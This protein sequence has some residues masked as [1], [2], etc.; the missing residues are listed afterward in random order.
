M[1]KIFKNKLLWLSLG[2]VTSAFGFTSCAQKQEQKQED[3]Y[4]LT[5]KA[6]ENY[7]KEAVADSYKSALALS[8][9]FYNNS[10]ETSDD[11]DLFIKQIN[12]KGKN[13]EV[14]YKGA[15][16]LFGSQ[17]YI[18]KINKI[19][20]DFISLIEYASKEGRDK[21][22]LKGK[23]K[24]FIKTV[25]KSVFGKD[26]W[27]Q[28][29]KSFLNDLQTNQSDL[30]SA[31][32]S[33]TSMLS[34]G[35]DLPFAI[36]KETIDLMLKDNET[37][38]SSLEYQINQLSDSNILAL[39]FALSE[40]DQKSKQTIL[41]LI[42][43]LKNWKIESDNDL[44]KLN[45]YD[46]LLQ[47]KP[48]P[49]LDERVKKLYFNLNDIIYNGGEKVKKLSKDEKNKFLQLLRE[50]KEEMKYSSGSIFGD[51]SRLWTQSANLFS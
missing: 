12:E 24:E 34:S 9:A 20:N 30:L 22:I 36:T 33:N 29:I 28:N 27:L 7:T 21:I 17:N 37:F 45:F 51:N 42:N 48:N 31:L 10:F 3:D 40:V 44:T 2:G 6:F 32:T 11:L 50:V 16:T 25:L 35:S 1:K 5:F 14:I 8:N 26:S 39:F 38:D 46:I 13:K 41:D 19:K 43:R 23:L 47:F 4:S 18:G 49:L 15:K